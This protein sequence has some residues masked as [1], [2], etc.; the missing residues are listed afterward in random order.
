VKRLGSLKAR[1]E[2]SRGSSVRSKVVRASGVGDSREIVGKRGSQDKVE[3]Q[4]VSG[5]R[6][7]NG[8]RVEQSRWCRRLGGRDIVSKQRHERV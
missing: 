6:L 8:S 3:R 2:K 1:A 5:V 4:K 7:F